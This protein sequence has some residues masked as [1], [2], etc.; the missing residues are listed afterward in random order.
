[1]APGTGK[2]SE[3]REKTPEIN[4]ELLKIVM[5]EETN[6][7]LEI[8]SIC[9]STMCLLIMPTHFQLQSTSSNTETKAA[10]LLPPNS[11]SQAR[12]PLTPFSFSLFS[13]LTLKA[14]CHLPIPHSCPHHEQATAHGRFQQ[15]SD[16]S[17]RVAI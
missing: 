17:I 9:D 4:D 11:S 13:L 14:S 5:Q 15:S 12:L 7:D 2:Q 1:M 3:W 10:W 6:G 8:L 16:E